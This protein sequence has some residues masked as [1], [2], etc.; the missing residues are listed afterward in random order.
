VLGRQR[1]A[2]S[3]GGCDRRSGL[4]DNLAVGA[5]RRVVCW[6]VG[7]RWNRGPHSFGHTL[8]SCERCGALRYR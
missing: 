6:V 2:G 5:L 1:E 4:F 3:S 8:W 7:H